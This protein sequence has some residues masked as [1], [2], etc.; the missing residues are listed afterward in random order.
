[1]DE[2]SSKLEIHFFMVL[3]LSSNFVFGVVWYVDSG[4]SKHMTSN[5]RAFNK[6]QEHETSMQ[7]EL[8]DDAT[9]LVAGV[10]SISFQRPLVDIFELTGVLYVP[11]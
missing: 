6:L 5:K 3:C 9:Y 2:L 10:G 8:G 4:A 7:V 11:S 1:V